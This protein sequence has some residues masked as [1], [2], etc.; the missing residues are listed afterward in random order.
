MRNPTRLEPGLQSADH[1]ELL[2]SHYVKVHAP[3][4]SLL[5]DLILPDGVQKEG[6]AYRS[7]AFLQS[8]ST[9]LH[10]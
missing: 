8:L 5:G 4:I 1:V 7:I 9:P 6:I 2:P 10:I 3:H